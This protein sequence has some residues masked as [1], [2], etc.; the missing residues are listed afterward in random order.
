M[1]TPPQDAAPTA[2][3]LPET[4][5]HEPQVRP[6]E[7]ELLISGAVVFS[8]LQ[9]P[10]W[11]DDQYLRV[12]VQVERG[13]F[14]GT[15]ML[16]VYIKVSL[17]TLIICFLTHLAARGYWVGLIGLESVYPRGINWKNTNYGPVMTEV[18]RERMGRVQAHIDSADRFCSTLFP[19][20]FALVSLCLY[21]LVMLGTLSGLAFLATRVAGRPDAFRWAFVGAAAVLL[22]IPTVAWAADKRL[23]AEAERGGRTH[24]VLRGLGTTVYYLNAMPAIGVMFI[25]LY[26]NARRSL[27]YPVMV[28]GI[29]VLF[30]FVFVHDIMLREGLLRVGGTAFYPDDAG[31]LAVEP[32]Y[33]ADQREP[34]ELYDRAPFIQSEVVRGPY[35]RLF[36]P[37]V[38]MLHGESLAE[39]CPGLRGVNPGGVRLGRAQ[40]ADSARTR[41]LLAC[42][43][44]LQPVTLNGRAITPVFRFTTEARTGVRG[45]V[46]QIPVQGLPR[47][48]NVLSV[49]AAPRSAEARRRRPAP[50]EPSVI[51]FWL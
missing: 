25:T 44:R 15:L 2:P 37:F 21:S 14:V 34:G 50:S 33:Y 43:T 18:Y 40:S 11:I 6:W 51:W 22:G 12:R 45:I 29:V 38:P 28:I 3:I 30:L 5:A 32:A 47:G 39:G 46:A 19:L 27:R 42:W 41:A 7:L 13:S 48:Q 8:L 31:E 10:G 49:A 23:G 16:Y 9:L 17:Y 26:S 35:V 20:A 36:I 1:Q 24:R 4:S